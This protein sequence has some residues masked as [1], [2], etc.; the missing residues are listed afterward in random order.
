MK[1]TFPDRRGWLRF[2]L[3]PFLMLWL[4]TSPSLA[5]VHMTFEVPSDGQ[6]VS[7]IS[8]IS[9]WAFST[10][11][12][13][14]TVTVQI[15]NNTPTIVPCCGERQDVAN[16]HKGQ[17]LN[18]GFGQIY[19]FNILAEGN[20]TIIIRVND[21]SDEEVRSHPISVVRPGGFEF[22]S[23][24]DLT[25][26]SAAIKDTTDIEIT[27][28]H[29]VDKAT[30]T[31]QEVTL[32]LAWQQNTQTL[33]IVSSENTGESAFQSAASATDSGDAQASLTAPAPGLASET[34]AEIQLAF[35][36]P[37]AQQA[38]SGVGILS[39]WAFSPNVGA[40]YPPTIEFRIDG[41]EYK[42][43]PCCQERQDV[44]NAYPGQEALALLS[45][46]GS[47]FNFNT[48]SS[49]SHAIE[50]RMRDGTGAEK[51]Q[52]HEVTVVKPGGFE[53]LDQ[54]DLSAA[55]ARISGR[56]L[57]L[58]AVKVRD[59]ATQEMKEVFLRYNWEPS[60]QCFVL[61]GDCGNGSVEPQEE[62]DGDSLAS[63]TCQ[64]LGF[65][66]ETPDL[67]LQCST[68]CLLDTTA[69]TG[70]PRLLVT[71]SA[72]DSVSVINTATNQVTAT[73]LVG[74]EPHG[75]VVNP[76]SP[77]AYVANFR[78]NSVSVIDTT[79]GQVTGTIPLGANRGPQSLVVSPD[80]N[81]VYVANDFFDS[82][83]IIDA[84]T[85]SVVGEIF[86]GTA[87]QD[88]ALT[89]DG[90]RAYVTNFLDNSVSVINTQ[91]GMVIKTI[92]VGEGPDGIAISPLAGAHLAYVANR[93]DNTAFAI[94]TTSNTVLGGPIGLGFPTK[95]VFPP[96][97]GKVYI[98][99]FDQISVLNPLTK[100]VLN[101]ILA[102]D[103]PLGMVV[104]P[105]GKRLYIA[106]FGED[107]GGNFVQ[108]VST[109]THSASADAIEV[110]T[111]P[112]GVALAP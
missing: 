105:N 39:G 30:L 4:A 69:C 104:T 19:N 107:G 29:A 64:S 82:V 54:F 88:I 97:G 108:V 50:V 62:C 59:K 28:A 95:V 63:Q 13:A 22:S 9:G 42:R 90:A 26:A 71:N 61:Q 53:F 103:R 98:A 31:D 18:S 52:T 112:F 23:R 96:D 66:V 72:S 7:G 15:D 102:A 93:L 47:V 74:E 25:F 24:L 65:N 76:T 45:G 14:V 100:T 81:T 11:G 21:G 34:A 77:T 86:V 27:Q 43:L 89:P 111:G 57:V 79:L 37:P 17:G 101:G 58:N 109:L 56:S 51:S 84:Q 60:C 99:N 16:A 70:G 1:R 10:T 6:K 106:L 20:H 38:A 91:T 44:A 48:Q 5:A 75:I 49:D 92:L 87:P 55:E 36:N 83:S 3:L 35:E 2:A 40:T 73:I 68:T 8:P 110:G 78:S 85:K 94:D 80:G 32:R 46:F 41:G 67:R 12:A 33:A